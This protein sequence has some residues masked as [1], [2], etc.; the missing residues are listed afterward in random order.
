[1]EYFIRRAFK[2]SF[3]YI[4]AT[5]EKKITAKALQVS[6]LNIDDILALLYANFK[7]MLQES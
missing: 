5:L 7:L 3:V 6:I 2:S 4:V 1:M